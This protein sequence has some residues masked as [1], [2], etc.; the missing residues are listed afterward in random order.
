[1]LRRKGLAEAEFPGPSRVFLRIPAVLRPR[2][3]EPRRAVVL[4]TGLGRLEHWREGGDLAEVTSLT[5]VTR[6]RAD[7]DGRVAVLGLGARLKPTKIVACLVWTELIPSP[8]LMTPGS[9]TGG[10]NGNIDG[11]TL[12]SIRG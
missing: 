9:R 5:E 7:T 4:R 12:A 6:A 1:M 8:R 10:N 11:D 2:Q 3:A